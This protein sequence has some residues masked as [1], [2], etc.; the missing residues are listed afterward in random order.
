MKLFI[1]CENKEEILRILGDDIPKDAYNFYKVE[2][3]YPMLKMWESD[4]GNEFYIDLVESESIEFE[5]V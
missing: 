4:L 1:N 2:K 5:E 3:K